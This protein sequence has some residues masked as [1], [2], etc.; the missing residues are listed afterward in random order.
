MVV[1]KGLPSTNRRG[2]DLQRVMQ[3]SGS[4]LPLQ[5]RP[6]PWIPAFAGMTDENCDETGEWLREWRMPTS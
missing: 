1:G 6:S 4:S 5:V 2:I 3:K